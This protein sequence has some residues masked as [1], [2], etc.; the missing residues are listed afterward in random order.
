MLDRLTVRK[1]VVKPHFSVSQFKQLILW[2][3]LE[4]WI[5]KDWRLA[6]NVTYRM[7]ELSVGILG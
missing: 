6:L 4:R 2:A 3:E 1:N 5:T 7:I